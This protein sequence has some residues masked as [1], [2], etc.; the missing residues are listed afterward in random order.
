M[1]LTN[2]ALANI[3][4]GKSAA[5]S[6]F[7]LI[8]IA[9]L[10]LNIGMTLITQINTFY[11]AKVVELQDPHV[12]M[13]MDSASYNPAYE[14][15]LRSHAEVRKMEKEEI[16]L[17]TSAKFRYGDS[18]M[19]IGA[20]LFNAD[21]KRDFP[22]LKLVEQLDTKNED[23]IYLPYSFKASGGY[24]LGETFTITYQNVDYSYRIAGF[25]EVTIF[26]T[27]NLGIVKF[28]LPHQE[29]IDLS[30]ELG[31]Q[32]N[33]ILMN[34]ILNDHTKA[35]QLLN[36]YKKLISDVDTSSYYWELDIES[37]KSINTMTINIIALILVAFAV[38]IV[39]VS[40][41]VI[42]FQVT[43]SIDD[44]VVNIGV[45]RAVGYTS[46]QIL[47][48][49]VL[50]FM[51]ITIP[52]GIVGAAIS[53]MIMPLFGGIITS[54]S[55][56]IWTLSFNAGINLISIVIVIILVLAVVLLTALR[57]H[58]L[59]PV[60]ALRGGIQTHSF[61]KNYFPIEKARGGLQFN[62]ACKTIMANSKQ[63]IMIALIMSAVSFASVFSVV[64][65]Y[66]IAADKTAFVHMVGIET[67]N[68]VVVAKS[69]EDKEDLIT[70]I[71]RM[72]GVNKVTLLDLIS[73][74]I[75]GQSFF[76][77]IS[78]DYSRLI[79]NTV[80]E[81][82]HPKYDNEIS[83][84]WLVA[85]QLQKSIG[86]TVE[87]EVGS[88]SY[89]YLITG[90]SQ[91][92]NNMG[93][94]TSLTLEGIQHII[95]EYQGF[96]FNVYLNDVSNTSFIQ[97]IKAQYGDLAEDIIDV[98]ETLKSQTLVYISTVFAVMV[99][100]FATTVLIV[101]LILYLV[102]KTMIL[103]RKKEFGIL[104]AIG[105]TTLQ[106][107]HQIALSFVP[108]VIAG[109]IVGG[110]LGSLLSNS[111]LTLLLSSAGIKNVQFIVNIPLVMLLCL[112]IMV[113]A[114]AV[115]LLVSRRI[116]HISAYGLITE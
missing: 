77:E 93:Q 8:F 102:I 83:I 26:G 38:V 21:V 15:F 17:L 74:N 41:I 23:D 82:R 85:K 33:G 20:A 111:L 96:V 88:N 11:D 57:I 24:K 16:I 36:E 22:S 84:S 30:A 50:Q 44:S 69:G 10:L 94:V 56:L 2:L 68:V 18:D 46:S 81:G 9:G 90:L 52:A 104:K 64:L 34:A 49:I 39:L 97:S 105:Y 54:L 19:S 61:R 1:K 110:L 75:D 71:E 14:D 70:N 65:Y 51:F 35:P 45:L 59:L 63:N 48:S 55:G 80:Y 31:E 79:N 108:V 27:N 47:W 76:T 73:T 78:D 99:L 107:M 60:A 112:G 37:V 116:K 13:V 29:Y 86:D 101:A 98:E 100:I 43:N 115:S 7:I 67:S 106:L 72:E 6:L 87:V 109:V 5:I 103:K 40:L 113:L 92:L 28:I 95:P 25:F 66:N 89:S 12:S 58:K 4:K 114:Y 91:S 32:A 62:L 42:K 3:K 53:Y